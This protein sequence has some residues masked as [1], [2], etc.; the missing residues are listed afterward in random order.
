ML[1]LDEPPFITHV[2]SW[3]PV[4]AP[5]YHVVRHSVGQTLCSAC[6]AG[7][8]LND[9]ASTWLTGSAKHDHDAHASM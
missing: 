8:L 2:L 5:T 7:M 1:V 9:V 4:I 3:H 6:F